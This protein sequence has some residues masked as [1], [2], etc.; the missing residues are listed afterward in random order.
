M[1]GTLS[2]SLNSSAPWIWVLHLPVQWQEKYSC[3]HEFLCFA[4]ITSLRAEGKQMHI[5]HKPKHYQH[6]NNL[7]L[8]F[9]LLA[10][11]NHRHIQKLNLPTANC[12]LK[13]DSVLQS[14]AAVEIMFIVWEAH[15][16][17]SVT[18]PPLLSP[19]H[20]LLTAIRQIYLPQLMLF[21]NRWS[22]LK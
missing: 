13:W 19:Y 15:G 2:F 1:R 7:I 6:K 16:S 14:I 17:L 22:T 18:P 11:K 9:N 4:Y 8:M 5:L 12:K 10:Y 3:Y 20:L 21:V